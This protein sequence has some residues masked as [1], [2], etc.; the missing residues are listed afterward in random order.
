MLISQKQKRI[1]GKKRIAPRVR[2]TTRISPEEQKELTFLLAEFCKNDIRT[3]K[4]EIIRVAL[5]HYL[6]KPYKEQEQIMQKQRL[7]EYE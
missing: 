7:N 3:S 2:C 4:N 6:N 1:K 5:N